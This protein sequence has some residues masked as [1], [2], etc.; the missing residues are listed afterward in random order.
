[1]HKRVFGILEYDKILLA[2]KEHCASDAGGEAAL[3]LYP[4]EEAADVKRLLQ[5]T[6][7][8]ESMLIKQPA[9]PITAFS[10][11][12]TEVRRLK[13]GASLNCTEI[14][15][16][17]SVMKAAKR[18]R[19]GIVQEDG[20][21]LLSRRAEPLFCSEELIR[22]IDISIIGEDEISDDA[23]AAL[24]DI[25][26]RIIR[27][28]EGV[29]EKLQALIKD[30]S[31][32]KYL[33]D[34]IVTMREGRF[35]VPVKQEHRG[36]VKG[37][38]HDQSGS[39][40]TLFV[41]PLAVVEANNRLRMLE[42]EEK[43]EIERILAEISD[44]LRP[45]AGELEEDVA[46][47]TYLDLVFAKA[48]LARSMRA[49]LPVLSEDGIID[50]R[51][52]RHPLI[53]PVRVVPVSVRLGESFKGLIITGPNTGGKTVTLKL[54]GLLQLMAQSGLF[55]P[56]ELGTRLPVFQK[57][58]AD[59]GDEQSIEQSLSTF[60]S[61][62]KNI[63]SILK[64][65]DARSLVLLDELGAGTDP[66]EG[67]ALAMSILEELEKKGASVLATTHYSEI[68]AFA[69][70]SRFYEN[71]GMEFDVESLSPTYRLF[72]GIPGLSNA[73]Q[74]S[75]KLGL[76]RSVIE[77]AKTLMS[78]ESLRFNEVITEA[79][80]Q[81]EKALK[82]RREAEKLK[83]STLELSERL[84]EQEQKA[85]EKKDEIVKKAREEALAIIKEA[86]DEAEAI[87][88]ELK[89]AAVNAPADVTRAAESARKRVKLKLEGLQAETGRR[90]KKSAV[91]AEELITGTSV[92][93]LSLDA[94]ATVIRPPDSRGNVEVQAGVMK[95]T[96]P[97]DDLEIAESR[98]KKAFR[99]RS[100]VQLTA[101]PISLEIDLRGMTID[102]AMIELDKYLD[103]AFVAGLT[104]VSVIH[105]K[106]TGALR[107]GIREFL[108]RH[109]H[110]GTFRDG[111][112]GEGEMG[113]T[114]VSLK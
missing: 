108:R 57:I 110:A 114:I 97:M 79:E 61:H 81:R 63:T 62:M 93:I 113:V 37:I 7:E 112:F 31:S 38:V 45:H 77:R 55:V 27:E 41:E 6:Y 53:D 4:A 104:E 107:I 74:I 69:V 14:L 95:L 17:G 66:A 80:A 10:D 48:S 18:A 21:G 65:A 111:R 42:A 71:A 78:E 40:Q 88:G 56:A 15:R 96:V 100:G 3:A 76:R 13:A 33:Q 35:V 47:L 32:A 22:T 60:S 67:A 23:S 54:C 64:Y 25:R 92:H 98:E 83:V 34:A 1:M 16:T 11:V 8:A 73:F 52:G 109:P 5:E 89:K 24:R 84:K 19:Q 90:R 101:K 106:G 72:I 82:E 86:R 20:E 9:H 29:R 70:S 87:I 12:R 44:R 99:E 68:K 51:Q 39:G 105:G 50:I 102:E 91:K 49:V 26:R 28:N 94:K 75:E 59:I 30:S 103:D 43:A 46:I 36:A 58:F 2:L 85:E